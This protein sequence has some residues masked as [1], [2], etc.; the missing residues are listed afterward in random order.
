M[1]Y[2]FLRGKV[3]RGK[4]FKIGDIVE[5]MDPDDLKVLNPNSYA[6]ATQ[7]DILN[8]QPKITEKPEPAPAAK[9]AS[10]KRAAEPKE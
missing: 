8:A 9:R 4:A 2:V 3:F 7:E 1:K 10:R 5:V 6:E